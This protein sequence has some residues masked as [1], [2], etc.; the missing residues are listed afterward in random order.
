[1]AHALIGVLVGCHH[2]HTGDVL[3]TTTSHVH[4]SIPFGFHAV[5]VNAHVATSI[6]NAPSPVKLL[7]VNVYLYVV[8]TTE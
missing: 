7:N 6:L 2:V 3:S 8:H 4:I 5:S 1:M